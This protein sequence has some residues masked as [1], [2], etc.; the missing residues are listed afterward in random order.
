[1]SV[2]IIVIGFL[3]FTIAKLKHMDICKSKR[4][5]V[6]MFNKAGSLE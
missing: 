2:Y 1:M 3:A 6:N 5:A 4:K